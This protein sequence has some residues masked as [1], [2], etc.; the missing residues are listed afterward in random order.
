MRGDLIQRTKNEAPQMRPWVRYRQELSVYLLIT[1]EKDI[2]IHRSW[3]L[4][5]LIA[6][7]KQVLDPQETR[8]H[9]R[10]AH[11]AN[12]DLRDHIQKFAVRVNA[13]RL[14]LVDRREFVYKETRLHQR[15][16]GHQ[17]ITCTVAQIRAE[18]KVCNCNIGVHVRVEANNRMKPRPKSTPLP[19]G[20]LQLSHW[21]FQ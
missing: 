5:R 7:A 1:E 8:H 12:V 13:D 4:D 20:H 3:F 2:E 16:H 17:Q 14:R 19:T 21:V 11:L 9:L 6:A 18:T 15:P 10:R